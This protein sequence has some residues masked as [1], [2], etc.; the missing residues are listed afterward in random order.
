MRRVLISSALL[1]LWVAASYYFYVTL[2]EVAVLKQ[3]NPRST[4][5]IELRETEYRRDGAR[6]ARRQIWISYERI[7]DHLKKAILISEDAGF[8]RH[9]GIDVNELKAA[10]TKDWQTLSFARGG[11]TITMQLARNLY[12]SPSKNPLR[13]LREIAIA[14]QLEQSLTKERIFELYLNVVEWGKNIYGAEA[15]AR[16]YFGKS[17]ADLDLL[18]AATLAALLPSPRSIHE[19]A[20][21]ARRN[22]ILSRLAQVGYLPPEGHGR[23]RSIPLFGFSHP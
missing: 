9:K 10:F 13:K 17:A 7:S 5:L 20:A 19:R 2:P 8:F 21:L 4:A 16:H 3:R 1:T 22:L 15:A 11:S 6:P 14:H 12:L 23:L 18:Q